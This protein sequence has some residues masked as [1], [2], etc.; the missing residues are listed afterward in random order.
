[1]VWD[2][3]AEGSVIINFF[4]NDTAGNTNSLMVTINK[5]LLPDLPSG[6]REIPFGNL[7]LLITGISIALLVMILRKKVKQK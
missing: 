1:M 5:D 6:G 3:L 2:T 7:Y 4:A